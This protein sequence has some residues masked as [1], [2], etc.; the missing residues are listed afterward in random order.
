VTSVP[1][2]GSCGRGSAGVPRRASTRTPCASAPRCVSSQVEVAARRRNPGHVPA[3]PPLVRLQL[4]ER[5]LRDVN[6][7]HVARVQ[8]REGAVDRVSHRRTRRAACLVARAE[9]DVV[10]EQ[11]T[12]ALGT[13]PPA[14]GCRRRCRRGTPSRLARRA[15]R[16]DAAPSSSPSRVCSF[17]RASSSSRAASHSSRLR[18]S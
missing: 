16:A 13:A 7:R 8:M 3:H 15:S 17:S 14:C 18:T 11:L 12:A 5:R 10:D 1:S 2:R 9:H 4:L 6:H